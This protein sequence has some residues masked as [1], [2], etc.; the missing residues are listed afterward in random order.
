MIPGAYEWLI[1]AF[2][3]CRV[4]CRK[5]SL[6]VFLFLFVLGAGVALAVGLAKRKKG[7][8]CDEDSVLSPKCC[9]EDTYICP[10]QCS[11]G[12]SLQICK[13]KK[14]GW[15]SKSAFDAVLVMVLT[16]SVGFVGALVCCFV[17]VLLR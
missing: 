3:V 1:K 5:G 6:A 11:C 8:Y 10:G 4:N 2:D 14:Y 9:F 15:E 12:V 17:H 7:C 13:E 16:G